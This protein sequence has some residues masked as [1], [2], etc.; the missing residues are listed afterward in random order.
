MLCSLRRCNF[1]LV[2][3]WYMTKM[4][5]A[6]RGAAKCMVMNLEL[7][8]ILSVIAFTYKK[9]RGASSI[10][11]KKKVFD[12]FIWPSNSTLY[13]MKSDIKIKVNVKIR[14]LKSLLCSLRPLLLARINTDKKSPWTII[15]PKSISSKR[16]R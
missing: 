3:T 5:F 1:Q 12:N 7:M 9:V 14:A 16:V 10:S 13:L 2:P 11:S 8:P 15:P 6:A 4:M